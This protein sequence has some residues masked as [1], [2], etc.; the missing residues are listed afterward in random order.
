MCHCFTI[1]IDSNNLKF[2]SDTVTLKV[3]SEES[4]LNFVQKIMTSIT[5]K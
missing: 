5:V 3:I 1:I 2:L 4:K